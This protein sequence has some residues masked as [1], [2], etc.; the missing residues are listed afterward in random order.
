[1]LSVSAQGSLKPE[2]AGLV[3]GM[4]GKAAQ[5]KHGTGSDDHPVIVVE[6]DTG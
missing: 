2:S 4:A 5:L 6:F 3:A 1:M